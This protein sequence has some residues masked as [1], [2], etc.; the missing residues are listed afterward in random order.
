MIIPIILKL[1]RVAQAA[2]GHAREGR[3]GRTV[4]RPGGEVI[5]IDSDKAKP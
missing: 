1:F 5:L 3:L 4:L 2:N